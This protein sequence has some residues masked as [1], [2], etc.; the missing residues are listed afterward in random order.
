MGATAS[1]P[2]AQVRVG[3][4]LPCCI[5]VAACSSLATESHTT[6]ASATSHTAQQPAQS[7]QNISYTFIENA[8]QYLQTT[9]WHAREGWWELS[10][11][12]WLGALVCAVQAFVLWK[13]TAANPSNAREPKLA[14]DTNDCPPSWWNAWIVNPEMGTC[15]SSVSIDIQAITSL[16]DEPICT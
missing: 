4:S 6:S 1:W 14:G 12:A 8:G 16:T 13:M 3:V 9:Y 10:A 11:I 5:L 15:L 2:L 7:I